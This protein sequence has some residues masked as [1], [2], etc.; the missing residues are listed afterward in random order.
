[1]GKLQEQRK[2]IREGQ[3]MWW[4]DWRKMNSRLKVAA[5]P[6]YGVGAALEEPGDHLI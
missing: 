6:G 3:S 2:V 1:M 4:K 5:V